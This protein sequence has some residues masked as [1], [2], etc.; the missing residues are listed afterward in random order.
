MACE[1]PDL[2]TRRFCAH[3]SPILQPEHQMC[4]MTQ[5]FRSVTA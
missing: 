4:G 1:R 5:T 2:D 3:S